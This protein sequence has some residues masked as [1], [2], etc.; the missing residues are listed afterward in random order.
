[1]S[2]SAWFAIG[3]FSGV[4]L[5]PTTITVAWTLSRLQRPLPGTRA[6]DAEVL[7]LRRAGL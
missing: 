6:H 1:M 3:M 5:W 4:L 7:R 2:S